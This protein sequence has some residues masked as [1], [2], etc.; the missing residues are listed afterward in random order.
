MYFSANLFN[1]YYKFL[2]TDDEGKTNLERTSSLAYFLALDQLQVGQ[3]NPNAVINMYK[4]SDSRKSFM[5][6][7]GEIFVI[8]KNGSVEY[9][10]NILGYINGVDGGNNS[11][12]S[13][14]GKTSFLLR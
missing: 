5:E 7:V 3:E 11:M 2:G 10:A 4:D 13:K 6:K 14:T 9:Q 12:S 8:A 1:N